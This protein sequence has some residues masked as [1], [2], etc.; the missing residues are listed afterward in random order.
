MYLVFVTNVKFS[1]EECNSFNMRKKNVGYLASKQIIGG[2]NAKKHPLGCKVM[3]IEVQSSPPKNCIFIHSECI[4]MQFWVFLSSQIVK[5]WRV[6]FLIYFHIL[7]SPILCVS[8]AVWH[9][10]MPRSWN[11]YF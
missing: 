3:T 10:S 7:F 2:S 9:Q 4:F 8:V 5:N 6:F 11:L 1:A